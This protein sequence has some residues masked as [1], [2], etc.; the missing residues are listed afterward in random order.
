MELEVGTECGVVELGFCDR[1]LLSKGTN[2][3]DFLQIT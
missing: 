2:M 1:G 3:V